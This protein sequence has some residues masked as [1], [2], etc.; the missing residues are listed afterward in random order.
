MPPCLGA[1]DTFWRQ[2]RQCRQRRQRR[3]ILCWFRYPRN[4]CA[5][6]TSQTRRKNNGEQQPWVCVRAQFMSVLLTSLFFFLMLRNQQC[7]HGTSIFFE[8]SIQSERL[9]GGFYN[10]L[11]D[12]NWL[13]IW[14]QIADLNRSWIPPHVW[15]MPHL[16][17]LWPLLIKVSVS[18]E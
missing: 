4:P 2:C 3:R 10:R 11:A 17:L 16:Y 9:A 15:A 13:Y 6:S 1:L 12:V 7:R 8:K 18:P 14:R 5:R